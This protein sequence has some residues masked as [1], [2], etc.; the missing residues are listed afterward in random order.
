[1]ARDAGRLEA[2]AGDL[3]Q[4]DV[5]LAT[6][7]C[8]LKQAE[9]VAP[10][11]TAA[12]QKLGRLDVVA[13]CAGDAK[14][15]GLEAVGDEDFQSTLEVKLMG[16]I[17]AVRAAIPGMRARGYGRIVLVGGL[18]GRNPS[19]GAVVG[20]AVNA[21]MANFA[22]QVAK[23]YAADG[24]TANVV[25]PHYTRTARWELRLDQMQ[26]QLGISREEA[27]KRAAAPMPIGRPVEP[28]EVADLVAF[29][30]SKRAGA[31]NGAIIPVDGG[32]AE[33]LY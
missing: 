1:V 27:A 12:E 2:L 10:A 24:I 29:L 14:R 26:E 13:F 11:I 15:G 28:S 6:F 32:S 3:K 31:I 4:Y 22:R 16:P 30:A 5:P 20:G 17:R 33:G 8:D 23:A 18:N 7:T 19:G 9:Q 25:D 21:G